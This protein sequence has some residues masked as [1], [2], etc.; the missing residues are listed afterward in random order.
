M[1]VVC[2]WATSSLSVGYQ[3]VCGLVAHLCSLVL[4]VFQTSSLIMF[5]KFLSL[6]NT[7]HFNNTEIIDYRI[8]LPKKHKPQS[9]I[10]IQLPNLARI[11]LKSPQ[12]TVHCTSGFFALCIFKASSKE[13][14]RIL[15]IPR[16]QE[17]RL[18]IFR[19]SSNESQRTFL[20]PQQSLSDFL[21][22]ELHILTLRKLS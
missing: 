15:V 4:T 11:S 9:I 19:A 2:L 7:N 17:I 12:D 5:G 6:S 16:V 10:L 21:H 13:S 3:P 22:Q 1:L 18:C 14:W 20:N 8:F